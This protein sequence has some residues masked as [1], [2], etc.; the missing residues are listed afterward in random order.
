M[1][2]LYTLNLSLPLKEKYTKEEKKREIQELCVLLLLI[3]LLHSKFCKCVYKNIR[4]VFF[5]SPFDHPLY[6]SCASKDYI[7][8]K[9]LKVIP[10]E[11]V[12]FKLEAS[13]LG[14]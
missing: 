3:I 12:Y 11:F 2:F 1:E 5:T 8:P 6:K 13:Y 10:M 9:K 4:V 7:N 14:S